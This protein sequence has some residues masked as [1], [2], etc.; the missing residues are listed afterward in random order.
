[1]INMNTII[2]NLFTI[3]KIEYAAVIP[4]S[5]C[6]IINRQLLER[7]CVGWIPQSAIVMLVPY[8]SGENMRRN[9]SLYAVPKDYHLYFHF[10]YERL[11]GELSKAYPQYHFKGFA[12]HS[13]ISEVLAGAQAG[14]G[15]IGDRF[16]LINETYGSYTFIGEILTDMPFEK[17]DLV[18]IRT[19]SHCGICSNA[20]PS[21]ERCLS[22]L[23]QQKGDLSEETKAL[24]RRTGI[25][26]GC[27]ICQTCCPMNSNPVKTPIEFFHED[28]LPVVTSSLLQTMSKAT[29]SA[30]A[31]GW[32]GRQT[33]LRNISLLEGD[34]KE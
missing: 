25:A 33:I 31:Y 24:I 7:T 1:M 27:D 28:L 13:P 23:T 18:D 14:L 5:A 9:V 30:R 19:C 32:R 34:K 6:T 16:Q 29:L 8:Y 21:K 3:E 2:K 17:Y 12:D 11:E 22:E 26:W 4:F 15:V 10:L 20:C